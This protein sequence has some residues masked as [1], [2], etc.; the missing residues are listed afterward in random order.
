[1]RLV[2]ILA[3]LCVLALIV[4]GIFAWTLPADVGYRYAAR[5]LGPVV[6]TGLRGTLWDGHADGVSVLGRDLGELDWHARKSPLLLHGNFVADLRIKGA[7]IDAAGLVTREGDGTLGARDLRFSVPAALLAPALDIGALKLLG[8]I[9]GVLTHA[10]LVHARLSD[11]D[12]NARWSEAGVSGEAEARFSDI[13]AE[14]AS[15]ADGSIAGRVHDDGSGDLE[16]NGTF[17]AHLGGF[18]AQATLR[19][20]NGNAQVADTLR[21]VGELQADGSSKLVVHGHMLKVL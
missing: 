11:A 1:M 14:F 17:N 2:K 8:T 19:A 9:N 4:A 13:L 12:G 15:Q 18:D 21:Y 16:V 7:D 3:V 5:Y 10:T 6:L 20:R